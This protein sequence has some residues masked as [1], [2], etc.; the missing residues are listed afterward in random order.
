MV[1]HDSSVEDVFDADSQSDVS[2]KMTPDELNKQI[3]G[4][5]KVKQF[6]Q[7]TENIKEVKVEKYFPDKEAFLDSVRSHM[8][9]KAKGG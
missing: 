6:P 9:T 1:E 3:Y 8:K 4:V 5:E 2:N 7:K